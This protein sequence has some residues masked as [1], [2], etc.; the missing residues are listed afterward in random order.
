MLMRLWGF[1]GFL[2]SLAKVPPVPRSQC[3]TTGIPRLLT[4]LVVIGVAGC[5]SEQQP[6]LETLSPTPSQLQQVS[7]TDSPE[8]TVRDLVEAV[9]DGNVDA[10]WNQILP[11]FR[12]TVDAGSAATLVS[13][14]PRSPD[15]ML[16]V[17]VERL[18][19]S[20]YHGFGGRIERASVPAFLRLSFSPQ[21]IEVP[22]RFVFPLVVSGGSWFAAD[23]N[24]LITVKTVSDSLPRIRPRGLTGEPCVP[25]E[26]LYGHV[27][28]N[29]GKLTVLDPCI[30]VEGIVRVVGPPGGPLAGDKI[31]FDVELSG[32]DLL[33]LN[34]QNGKTWR[35]RLH[36]EIVPADRARLPA[37]EVGQ[38]LRLSGPWVLD[39]GHEAWSEIHPVRIIEVI[40]R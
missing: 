23:S 35:G 16:R 30:T 8:Q 11:A 13:D 39:T 9:N 15:M 18:E 38:R 25:G 10:A 27:S 2:S 5:T 33:L 4:L 22:I 32:P 20:T 40:S 34:E 26:V 21:S 36:V 7:P 28:M 29:P 6:P 1:R 24:F 19:A 3:T 31:Q 17:T 12:D 37:P 14:L